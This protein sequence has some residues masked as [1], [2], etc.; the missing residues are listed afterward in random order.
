M[1]DAKR[2]LAECWRDLVGWCPGM[3]L[4]PVSHRSKGGVVSIVDRRG[5]WVANPDGN[6]YHWDLSCRDGLPDPDA[7]AN[8]GVWLAWTAKRFGSAALKVHETGGF[9]QT[10]LLPWPDAVG[11]SVAAG[12]LAAVCR[13][14]DFI[15]SQ[16]ERPAGRT[17]LPPS[18]QAWW[19]E[20]QEG[21]TDAD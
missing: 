11:S 19:A 3:A 10:G 7:P 14:F 4:R 16:T 8:W 9:A 20:P 17:D 18:V 1:D 5:L 6:R 2:K 13:H 15:A 21:A 12:L